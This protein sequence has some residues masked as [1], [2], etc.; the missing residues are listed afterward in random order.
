MTLSD[1]QKHVITGTL[2]SLGA[3][4]LQW[5]TTRDWQAIVTAFLGP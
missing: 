5:I 2:A 1:N 4:L 3:V